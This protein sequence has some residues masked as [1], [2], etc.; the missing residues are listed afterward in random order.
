MSG[1]RIVE[2][3]TVEVVL[4]SPQDDYT[5]ALLAD[6]PSMELALAAGE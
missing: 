6:T 5:K 3:G 1:G 4:N 2:Y